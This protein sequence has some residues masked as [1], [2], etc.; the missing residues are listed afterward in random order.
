[1]RNHNKGKTG[2][3]ALKIDMSKAYDKSEWEYMEKVMT[4]MDFHLR[5]IQLMMMCIT[6][7]LYSVLINGKPHGL[8]TPT[9]GLC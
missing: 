9:R 6:T 8:I 4:K 3:M 2:F 7:A 1:M 5:W